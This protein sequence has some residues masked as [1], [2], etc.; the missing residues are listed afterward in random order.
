MPIDLDIREH[1]VLGPIIEEAEQKGRSEGRQ[2][3]EI[4]ALRRLIERRF[5]ALPQWAAEKIGCI[6][7]TPVGRFERVLDAPSLAELL[8]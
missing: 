8:R 1:E 6:I 5:G 4:A 2:E 7:D 3:G